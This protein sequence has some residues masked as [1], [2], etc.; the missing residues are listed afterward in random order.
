MSSGFLKI[1]FSLLH[2]LFLLFFPSLFVL[3]VQTDLQ[4]G[5]KDT[6]SSSAVSQPFPVPSLSAKQHL[7]SSSPSAQLSRTCSVCASIPRCLCQV[8]LEEAGFLQDSSGYLCLL[9]VPRH[10]SKYLISV[11]LIFLG[12]GYLFLLDSPHP[13]N[14]INPFSGHL[15]HFPWFLSAMQNRLCNIITEVSKNYCILLSKYYLKKS[16]C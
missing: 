10:F 15:K 2:L 13:P 4:A 7:I 12:T 6:V 8:F 5:R 1:L 9:V 16:F 3:T 14:T 11:D